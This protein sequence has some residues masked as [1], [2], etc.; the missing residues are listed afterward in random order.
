[1]KKDI[2]PLLPI[3]DLTADRVERI[4]DLQNAMQTAGKYILI[5]AMKIGDELMAE[6]ADRPHGT[7]LPWLRANIGSMGLQSERTAHDYM[8]LSARRGDIERLMDTEPVE[9]IRAALRMLGPSRALPANTSDDAPPDP[10]AD[11]TS[12]SSVVT[13]DITS[14]GKPTNPRSRRA[15]AISNMPNE[16]PID[17]DQLRAILEWYESEQ[18]TAAYRAANG[19]DRAK[20]RKPIAR[21]SAVVKP[22]AKR[23]LERTAKRYDMTQGEL[24]EQ[25]L[26]FADQV[27]A[28]IDTKA[29][30]SNK[31]GVGHGKR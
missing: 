13:A 29:T 23:A 3:G 1:M 16:L 27:A 6:K 8:R 5:A 30:K 22:K 10:S 26:A 12:A 9:S 7:F 28:Q 2:R 14:A 15:F 4:R 19:G 25:L 21:V 24:I 31:R 20:P 11:I 18:L 17:P